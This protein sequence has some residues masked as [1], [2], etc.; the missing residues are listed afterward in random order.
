MGCFP[1]KKGDQ[2]CAAFVLVLSFDKNNREVT[3]P[4]KSAGTQPLDGLVGGKSIKWNFICQKE[5][6]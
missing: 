2:T 3:H 4:V 5:N 1:S 6:S